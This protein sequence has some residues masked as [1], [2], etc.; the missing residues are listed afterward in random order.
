[1]LRE[2]RM[3]EAVSFFQTV[4]ILDLSHSCPERVVFVHGWRLHAKQDFR[5]KSSHPGFCTVC[6]IMQ[7]SDRMLCSVELTL[8]HDQ[9]LAQFLEP[10][11][12][13]QSKKIPDWLA[14]LA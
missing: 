12:R 1:M 9:L 11:K 3:L 2:E 10:K 7:H 13:N 4:A 14:M 5:T 8:T 6:L